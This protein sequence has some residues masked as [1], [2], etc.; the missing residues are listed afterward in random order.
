VWKRFFI[1]PQDWTTALITVVLVL[2]VAGLGA[3]LIRR[4]T[5]AGL[6]AIV[7]ETQDGD[8]PAV[9]G[10]VWV[11]TTLSFLLL[12]VLLLLPA[13][14]L[15]GLQPRR[16]HQLQHVVAWVF[17]SGVRVLLITLFAYAFV[18][19]SGLV[20]RRF[21]RKVMKE[22]TL[23]DYEQAKRAR[24]L[25]SVV[26]KFMTASIAVVAS[27][28]ILREFGVDITPVLTGA[29]IVGVA[30]GFGAQTLVRDLIG[31]FFLILEDQV[32]VGDHAAINGV[33][34]MV[35]QINL[36]TIVLRDL[37]GTVHVFPNGAINTLANQ[38]KDFSY[39]LID[40]KISSHDNPDRIAGIL[41]GVGTEMQNDPR[42]TPY[43]L[44]PVEVMG[45]VDVFTDQTITMRLRI[46]T[47]PLKQ[48]EIGREF[49]KRLKRAFDQRGVVGP[50][51][52]HIVTVRGSTQ[53]AETERLREQ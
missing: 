10:P 33:E 31:G 6:T 11:V 37:E 20:V 39:C 49:R 24:T 12:S 19:A 36:R 25:G 4:L 48:W 41:E 43:I 1:G 17:D 44:K 50:V 14:E 26:N 45:V 51:P 23:D 13:F 32:R 22:A 40:L 21:E 5:A 29:G 18:R 8:S 46:K 15:A 27:L 52:E 9:K 28:M 3:A 53:D 16:G 42:Y 34:G 38:T 47:V 7:G 2:L 30:L 35:E